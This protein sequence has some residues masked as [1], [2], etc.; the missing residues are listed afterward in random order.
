MLPV[1]NNISLYNR[2]SASGKVK[3]YLKE[4]E[5]FSSLEVIYEQALRGN[6]DVVGEL[7]VVITYLY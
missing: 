6:L 7:I 4:Q 5:R 3:L 1:V 2:P